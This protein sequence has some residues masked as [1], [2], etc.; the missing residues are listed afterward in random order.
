M[1]ILTELKDLTFFHSAGK[2]NKSDHFLSATSKKK[3]CYLNLCE[4]QMNLLGVVIRTVDAELIP[5]F[6]NPTSFIQKKSCYF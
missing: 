5:S 3:F 1:I 2:Q 6:K 4:T